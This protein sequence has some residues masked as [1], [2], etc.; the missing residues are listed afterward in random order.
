MQTKAKTLSSK[1]VRKLDGV[2]EAAHFNADG[3]LAW[4]RAYERRG[5]TWSD[6]V[7]LDRATLLERLRQGKRFYV[8]SRRELWASEFDLTVPL[9]RVEFYRGEALIT[10]PGKPRQDS[11]KHIPVV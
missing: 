7:L 1:R 4:V 6:T 3:T 9:R 10:G 8:G 5:P 2:I 11:L